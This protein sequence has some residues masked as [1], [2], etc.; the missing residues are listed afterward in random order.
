MVEIPLNRQ[1]KLDVAG[2]VGNDGFFV[3]HQDMGMKEPYIGR[4]P[5]I[6]GEF[7]EDITNYYAT[8]EQIPTVCGLG[9]LVTRT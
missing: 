5:I 1:G 9:V 8:S 3:C 6:S 4:V 2:A 7:A